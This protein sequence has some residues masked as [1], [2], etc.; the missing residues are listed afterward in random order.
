[1]GTS[2]LDFP[3]ETEKR[4][5]S[6]SFPRCFVVRFPFSCISHS[7][8]LLLYQHAVLYSHPT[9]EGSQGIMKTYTAAHFAVIANLWGSSIIG[10]ETLCLVHRRRSERSLGVAAAAGGTLWC[11]LIRKL[12]RLIHCRIHVKLA[13]DRNITVFRKCCDWFRSSS[14][15]KSLFER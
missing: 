7:T 14:C 10:A 1:M 5:R 8:G 9:M 13:P 15:L 3:S 12:T 11:S 4:W 6:A 2:C